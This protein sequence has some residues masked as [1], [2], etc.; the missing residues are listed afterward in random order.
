MEGPVKILGCQ[1]LLRC[2]SCDKTFSRA[3]SLREVSCVC[4]E[5]HWLCYTCREAY[6]LDLESIDDRW[7]RKT[8]KAKE[9]RICPKVEKVA[10]ILMEEK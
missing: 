8:P 6:A 9:K 3:E 4:G 5:K 10:R 1:I 7:A 2:D